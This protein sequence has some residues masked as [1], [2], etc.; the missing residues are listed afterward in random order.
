[1]ALAGCATAVSLLSMVYYDFQLWSHRRPGYSAWDV[2]FLP[3]RWFRGAMYTPEGNRYRWRTLRQAGLAMAGM[4]VYGL[5]QDGARWP[6]YGTVMGIGFLT[7][8]GAISLFAFRRG[9]GRWPSRT[10]Q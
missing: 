5:A 7:I 6:A 10:A 2:A 3:A 9:S 1:M 8:G 4:G